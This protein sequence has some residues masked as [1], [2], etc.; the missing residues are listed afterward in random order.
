MNTA[1]F[2]EILT[3]AEKLKCNTRHSWTSS[4][5]HESVAEHSW[6]IA[7]MALL[8]RD[9]FPETDMDK[10]IRMCLIHDLGEAFTG[11][12]PTFEKK[13]EDSKKEDEIFLKWI[14]TFPS[15]YREE[16][17]ELLKE[18]NERKTDEAKLYKALD[19]LEA[20][21][22]HNEADISTWIPLEYDL[23]F[24]YG[25]DKVE[26]STYLKKLKKEIDQRTTE[27]IAQKIEA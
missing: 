10:V 1:T 15:P 7:L 26:F 24:T 27:K 20:V 23:Q 6:R 9:E 5:R 2:L 11:D 16:F 13:D 25:A 17:T 14:A 22:Q 3:V 12:I 19:N 4:G 8:M 21:I 18:M